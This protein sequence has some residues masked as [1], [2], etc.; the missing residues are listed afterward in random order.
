MGGKF[1]T[2]NWTVCSPT[3]EGRSNERDAEAQAMFEAQ[4]LWKKKKDSGFFE[5][6][7][8]IDKQALAQQ[9]FACQCL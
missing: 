7:K 9:T 4:A 8:D 6:I 1:Q 3:N 2:T 5:S